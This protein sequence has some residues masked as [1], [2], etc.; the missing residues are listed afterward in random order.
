MGRSVDDIMPGS[1]GPENLK[2]LKKSQLG[3]DFWPCRQ[4]VGLSAIEADS[5]S[6]V[7]TMVLRNWYCAERWSVVCIGWCERLLRIVCLFMSKNWSQ[8]LLNAFVLEQWSHLCIW[9]CLLCFCILYIYYYYYYWY[10]DYGY[11]TKLILLM[12]LLAAVISFEMQTDH[13]ISAWRSDLELINQK[14]RT[15]H[16]VD[17]A[18]PSKHSENL[19]EKKGKIDWILLKRWKSYGTWEWQ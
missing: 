1:D 6:W 5:W 15:C 17:F 3:V 16:V 11:T 2:I 14:K 10:Y 8:K 4:T 12:L 7:P 18:V 19:K 9:V 13:Q